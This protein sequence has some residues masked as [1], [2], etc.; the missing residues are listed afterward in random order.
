[1]LP[2]DGYATTTLELSRVPLE[3]R[4]VLATSKESTRVKLSAVVIEAKFGL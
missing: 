2:K 4:G 3:M 1:M